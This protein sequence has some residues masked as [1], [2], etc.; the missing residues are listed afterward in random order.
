MRRRVSPADTIFAVEGPANV[1]NQIYWS[2]GAAA[3]RLPLT[4][5]TSY[6]PVSTADNNSFHMSSG[7]PAYFGY[8]DTSARRYL[9]LGRHNGVANIFFCDGH[10][11]ALRVEKLGETH[12]VERHHHAEHLLPVDDPGRLKGRSGAQAFAGLQKWRVRQVHVGPVPEGR[13]SVAQRFIAG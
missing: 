8:Q 5:F 1:N 2:A 6:S 11:K 4:P 13:L 7:S 10:A 9:G 12:P 3:P